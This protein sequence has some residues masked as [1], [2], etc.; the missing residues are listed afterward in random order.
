MGFGLPERCVRDAVRPW[1]PR[2]AGKACGCG[3]GESGL[4]RA[5]VICWLLYSQVIGLGFRGEDVRI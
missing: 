2:G 5:C 1:G 4:C 3:P